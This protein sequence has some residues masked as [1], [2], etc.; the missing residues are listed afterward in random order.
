MLEWIKDNG[1]LLWVLFMLWLVLSSC[2]TRPPVVTPINGHSVKQVTTEFCGIPVW[3]SNE[4]VMTTEQEIEALD[5]DKRKNRIKS[6]ERQKT[7]AFWIGLCL[8]IAAPVCVIVGYLSQG[9]KF[10]GC[11]AALCAALGAAFWGFES[12]LPYL[13]WALGG[14]ISLAVLW[15]MWKLEDF[16]LIKRLKDSDKGKI[17]GD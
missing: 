15:T 17:L 14:L 5:V 7:A 2:T 6:L 10:W 11:M 16:S 12:L 4:D 3:T 8:M 9:W 13:K 1:W